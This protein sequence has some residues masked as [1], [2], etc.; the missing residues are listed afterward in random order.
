M[1]NRLFARFNRRVKALRQKFFLEIAKKLVAFF[2]HFI[3]GATARST[4]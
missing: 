4:T 3:L 2:L 1:L